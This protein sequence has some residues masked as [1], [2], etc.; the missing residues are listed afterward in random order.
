MQQHHG[1]FFCVFF[2]V[3]GVMANVVHGFQRLDIETRIC[4]DFKTF[5]AAVPDPGLLVFLAHA[6]A[7]AGDVHDFRYAGIERQRRRQDDAK[8]LLAAIREN[9]SVGNTFAVEIDIALLEDGDIVELC[10]HVEFVL[11]F[12][13]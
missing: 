9:D 2:Y 12:F 3:S 5:A 1:L 10:S 7:A 11:I 13:S 8:R 4:R 6:A